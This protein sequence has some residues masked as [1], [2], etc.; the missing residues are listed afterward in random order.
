MMWHWPY[1][2]EHTKKDR[3][4]KEVPNFKSCLPSKKKTSQPILMS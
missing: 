3:V 4:P 1:T 2:L